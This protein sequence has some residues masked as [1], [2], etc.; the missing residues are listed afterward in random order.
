[1]AANLSFPEAIE[2]IENFRSNPSGEEEQF[3][4]FHMMKNF[5]IPAT[6]IALGLDRVLLMNLPAKY[7]LNIS[8]NTLLSFEKKDYKK[9]DKDKK[10]DEL[11]E[12]PPLLFRNE[13]ESIGVT[14]GSEMQERKFEPIKIVNSSISNFDTTSI[15]EGENLI[16]EIEEEAAPEGTEDYV[17]VASYFAIWNTKSI[18]PYDIDAKDFDEPVDIELYNTCFPNDSLILKYSYIL[19][20]EEPIPST[21]IK[22]F[23]AISLLVMTGSSNKRLST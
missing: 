11:D 6:A 15:D 7:T 17:A 19:R 14:A 3:H 20:S 2:I 5:P 16:V 21:L 12:L 1:M 4:L 10:K 23:S 9:K 22:T 13:T 18:D 8:Q